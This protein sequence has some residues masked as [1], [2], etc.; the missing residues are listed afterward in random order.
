M[1]IKVAIPCS[2]DIDVPVVLYDTRTGAVQLQRTPVAAFGDKNEPLVLSPSLGELV[3][4]QSSLIIDG[5]PP[6]P[7]GVYMHRNEVIT[8]AGVMSVPEFELFIR[9][10]Y[11]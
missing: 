3:A 8:P 6:I 2:R 10:N 5:D 7:L 4:A 1:A 11:P 9:E